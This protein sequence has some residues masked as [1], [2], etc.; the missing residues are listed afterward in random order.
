MTNGQLVLR[1]EIDA[2]KYYGDSEMW[3]ARAKRLARLDSVP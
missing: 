2:K 3:I 1:T